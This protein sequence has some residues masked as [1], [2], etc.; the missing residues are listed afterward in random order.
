MPRIGGTQ[1]GVFRPLHRLNPVRHGVY[2]RSGLQRI[3]SVI[4]NTRHSLKRLKILDVGCG[5]GLL[6]EPLAR[7]GGS[8]TGLDASRKASP[9]PAHAKA[10]A[11]IDYRVASVEELASNLSVVIPAKAGIACA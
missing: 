6:A 2:P 8:V 3:S 10:A 5:G 9:S 11:A 7:L 4:R 1:N